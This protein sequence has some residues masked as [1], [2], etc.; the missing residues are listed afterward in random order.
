MEAFIPY[1]S[2]L[3]NV[4]NHVLTLLVLILFAEVKLPSGITIVFKIQKLRQLIFHPGIMQNL[5]FVTLKFIFSVENAANILVLF[6]KPFLAFC[7]K[8]STLTLLLPLSLLWY[9]QTTQL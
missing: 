5:F 3:L 4:I 7:K 6:I 1:F 2:L 9:I 8:I